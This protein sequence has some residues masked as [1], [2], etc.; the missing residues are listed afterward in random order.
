MIEHH[1]VRIVLKDNQK[2]YYK[3]PLYHA[4]ESGDKE[5]T[6]YLIDVSIKNNITYG[7]DEFNQASK[8]GE[9]LKKLLDSKLIM[10]T[11]P[12]LTHID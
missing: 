11:R 12:I 8:D 2:E 3:T 4:I 10:D 5:F 9:L 7:T 6:D 1:K